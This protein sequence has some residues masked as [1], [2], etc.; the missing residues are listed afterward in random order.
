MNA[1]RKSRHLPPA[2]AARCWEHVLKRDASADGR[3]FTA[4]RTTGIY[5]RPSCPARH[6]RRE[7]VE[8]FRSA[9]QARAGGYRA[10]K[11]CR[12]DGE[13][14]L[15]A[16]AR[17]VGKVLD[18]WD[19]PDSVPTL[20][21]LSRLSGVSP[22]H[23]LRQF[24]RATGLTPRQYLAARRRDA[25][26]KLSRS[27]PRVTD[28]IF[29][30]GYSSAS[31][32]YRDG[33]AQRGMTLATY[34]QGGAGLTLD[35]AIAP[36]AVGPM[37]VAASDRGVCTIHLGATRAE[38]LRLLREEFPNAKLREDVR[39]LAR[40]VRAVVEI[41][42]G[43]RPASDLPLDIAGTA[44]QERAW[45]LLM[46]IPHGQTAS[47][48]EV[49]RRMGNPRAFRAVARAC[50]TNRVPLV[51]PCHRVLRSDGS[52]GGYRYG[53]P[54]KKRLLEHEREAAAVRGRKRKRA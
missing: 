41:L 34:R 39:A 32:A 25:V 54:L 27:R 21:E 40:H 53:L 49:A 26:R 35:W 14:T 16:T 24:Q 31:A 17:K 48:Q 22:F 29:E 15:A 42:D 46:A 6:P 23:L 20:K 12:P 51:I 52:L 47:Y 38:L 28:A 36:T 43:S 50:A 37:L 44:F 18:N 1:A 2:Q 5:C 10:C 4:V 8:F 45:K 3:F 33:A 11:R 7:N 30:A 13:S 19:D 9:E